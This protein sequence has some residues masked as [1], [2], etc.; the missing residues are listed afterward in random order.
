MTTMVCIEAELKPE[1][2]E[3]AIAFLKQ[4]FPE[5]R[6]YP[7]CKG[8]NAYVHEDGKTMVFVELW[9]AKENFE[10]YLAWRQESGSFAE[11]GDMVVG[12][13]NIRSFEEVDA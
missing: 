8:I 5:T 13:M 1:R 7:G 2:L 3:E 6:D 9:E 4:R 12:E 11:F 10:S